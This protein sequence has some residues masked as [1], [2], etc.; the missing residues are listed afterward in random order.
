[1]LLSGVPIPEYIAKRMEQCQTVKL[2]KGFKLDGVSSH[3]HERP[4]SE[5]EGNTSAQSKS[6]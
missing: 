5:Q 3:I 6:E 4:V 2:L 1:M